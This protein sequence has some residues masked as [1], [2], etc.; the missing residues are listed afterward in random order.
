M[1]IDG[2]EPI[3]SATAAGILFFAVAG[4]IHFVA[5]WAFINASIRRIGAARASAIGA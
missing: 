4:V 5:G 1:A 2:V 3:R